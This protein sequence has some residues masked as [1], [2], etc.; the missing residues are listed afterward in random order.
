MESD[1]KNALKIRIQAMETMNI[2][3]NIFETTVLMAKT[4]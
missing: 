3:W 1:N 4:N 2:A